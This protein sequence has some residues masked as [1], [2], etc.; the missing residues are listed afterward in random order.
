VLQ[1]QTS[2]SGLSNKNSGK[3]LKFQCLPA[4][5]LFQNKP[6]GTSKH[7]FNGCAL[8]LLNIGRGY[9]R[10]LTFQADPNTLNDNSNYFWSDSRPEGFAFELE[11]VSPGDKFTLQDTNHTAAG[12]LEILQNTVS[13]SIM[14]DN[15]CLLLALSPCVVII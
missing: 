5:S 13:Y 11:V 7:M 3:K 2:V 9:S 6:K 1:N 12:T 4:L 15:Y 14:S 8:Q 10:R